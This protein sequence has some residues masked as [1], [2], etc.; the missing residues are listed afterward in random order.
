MDENENEEILKEMMNLTS[1]RMPHIKLKDQYNIIKRL[2]AGTYGSVLLAEH[3]LQG[4]VMALKLMKKKSTKKEN[5]LM[6]YCVSLCLAS[7]PNIIKTFAVAFET[8]KYFSFAQELATAG[9]LHSIIV[10]HVGLPD[11]MVKR[12]AMQLAEA[13]DFMHSKALVHRDVK[14]DNV[15]L[16]DSDC[17]YIKLA[18]FGL[19]RLE[20][21]HISPLKGTVPYS[22]PELCNLGENET[23]ELD[24]SL[25]VWAFGIVLFCISTGYFPWDTALCQDEQYEKFVLWQTTGN[26][27]KIPSQWKQFTWRALDMFQKMLTINAMTRSPAIEVQKYLSDPWK[28]NSVNDNSNLQDN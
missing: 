12:C 5:F 25:D 13:L 14:L 1:K 22:A 26:Y 20:G 19:T 18:D 4:T 24:S 9:D 15:L 23:L 10:P 11:I 27:Q 17:H 21:F 28:M 6:E 16:F 3:K 8:S 2:G 7:H